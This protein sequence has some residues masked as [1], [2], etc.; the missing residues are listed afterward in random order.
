MSPSESFYFE[1]KFSAPTTKKKH[2]IQF[3]LEKTDERFS[4]T[5]N[6]L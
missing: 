2:S 3:Q 6:K 4:F 5:F 1:I